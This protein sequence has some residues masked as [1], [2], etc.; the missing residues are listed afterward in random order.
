MKLRT[1]FILLFLLLFSL[2]SVNLVLGIFLERTERVVEV[3][4]NERHQLNEIAEEVVISSQWQT[5]FARTYITTKDPRRFDWYYKIS[6]ILEGRIARP[7]N[8]S[9]EFWDLVTGG[10]A[11]PPEGKIE[12]GLPIEDRFLQHNI[13][14]QELNKLR[15]ARIHLSKLSM[16]AEQCGSELRN[17]LKV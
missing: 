11:K 3:S 1:T 17:I 15:E 13:T 12:D 16:S 14:P 2:A 10:I 4:Q 9:L 7:D 6:D 5:R 8:Y